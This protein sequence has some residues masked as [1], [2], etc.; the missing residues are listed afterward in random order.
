MVF[1]GFEGVPLRLRPNEEVPLFRSEDPAHKKPQLVWDAHVQ[2]YDLNKAPELA[3]YTA[4][5]QLIARGKAKFSAEE[6]LP[7]KAAWKIFL[8]WWTPI[9]EMP[10]R[11]FGV[12]PVGGSNGQIASIQFG[13]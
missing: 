9:A 3:A 10:E 12:F 13:S 5:M 4:V 8:R 11:K 6:R 1:P 7:Y 2:V